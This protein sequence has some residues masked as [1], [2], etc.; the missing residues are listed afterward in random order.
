METWATNATQ[1]TEME[2]AKSAGVMN[3]GESE[4]IFV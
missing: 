4:F 1:S 3:D 2:S